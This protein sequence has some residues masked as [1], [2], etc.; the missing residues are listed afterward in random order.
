MGQFFD[1]LRWLDIVRMA[2][3][4]LVVGWV[5]PGGVARCQALDSQAAGPDHDH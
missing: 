1:Q 2:I 5:A 4:Y 3:A